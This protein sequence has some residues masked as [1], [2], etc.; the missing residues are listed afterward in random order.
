[1]SVEE[2]VPIQSWGAGGS[3]SAAIMPLMLMRSS[4]A[5]INHREQSKNVGLENRHHDV[6][7]HKNGGHHQISQAQKYAGHL[8]ARE[9]VSEQTK[10]QRER[11]R[12]MAGDLNR[13]HQ[14]RQPP[15][16]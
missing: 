14:P 3:H 1:M 4:H 13:Y 15:H 6:Q 5:H 8:L 12:Q 7:A 16:G 2:V 11:A 10:R 9:H